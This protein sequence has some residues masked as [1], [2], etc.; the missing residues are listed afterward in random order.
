[1]EGVGEELL[2]PYPKTSNRMR[3]IEN[4]GKEKLTGWK[5]MI[6][7]SK[8]NYLHFKE[9]GTVYEKKSIKLWTYF[10]QMTHWSNCGGQ[11]GLGKSTLDLPRFIQRLGVI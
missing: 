9:S 6:G 10:L 5:K 8:E 3:S 11:K 7:T 1:M 4:W 2:E